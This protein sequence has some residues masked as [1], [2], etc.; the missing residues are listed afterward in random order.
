MIGFLNFFI[1]VPI[2]VILFSLA[3]CYVW[4]H[5]VEL[6]AEQYVND[7]NFAVNAIVFNELCG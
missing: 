4:L 5:C 3:F 1:R 6:P 2:I 7:Y